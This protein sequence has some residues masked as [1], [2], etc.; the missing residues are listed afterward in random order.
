MQLTID[1]TD[2][3]VRGITAARIAHNDSPPSESEAPFESDEAYLAWVISRA[4]DSYALQYS[5]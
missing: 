2:E 1:F 5:S 4:A 3:Q